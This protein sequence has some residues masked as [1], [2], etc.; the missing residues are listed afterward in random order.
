MTKWVHLTYLWL[1]W[2][3]SVTLY[4]QL[5]HLKC[6]YIQEWNKSLWVSNGIIYC[7]SFFLIHWGKKHHNVLL[8]DTQQLCCGFVWI[9]FMTDHNQAKWLG[10]LCLKCKLLRINFLFI[11]P[12]YINYIMLFKYQHTIYSCH[13]RNKTAT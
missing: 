3:F 13:H 10:I 2:H 11:E 5:I 1:F 6:W 9:I 12:L 7:D 8:R 4:I